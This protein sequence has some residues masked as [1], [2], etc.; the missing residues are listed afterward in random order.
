MRRVGTASSTT[1]ALGDR[2]PW[3]WR[4]RQPFWHRA[5]GRPDGRLWPAR[6]GWFLR[7]AALVVVEVVALLV[8]LAVVANVVIPLAAPPTAPPMPTVPRGALRD[9]PRLVPGCR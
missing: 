1:P 7:L 3:C 6:V 2:L 5:S 9:C 4:L 8:L